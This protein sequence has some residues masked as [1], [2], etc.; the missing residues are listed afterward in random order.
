MVG[1][2]VIVAVADFHFGSLR[3]IEGPVKLGTVVGRT[4]LDA[5]L[6]MILNAM[7]GNLADDL[8]VSGLRNLLAKDDLADL[9]RG[10]DSVDA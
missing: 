6:S 2:A 4:A 7:L 3:F 10:I 1:P 9:L 8:R 5:D